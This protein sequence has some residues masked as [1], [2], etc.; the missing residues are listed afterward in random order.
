MKIVVKNTVDNLNTMTTWLTGKWNELS[1]N[2]Y[3]T[4]IKILFQNSNNTIMIAFKNSKDWKLNTCM[5]KI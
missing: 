1:E 2:D 4:K 5:K 3:K